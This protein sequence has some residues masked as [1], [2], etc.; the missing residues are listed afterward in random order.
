MKSRVRTPVKEDVS[1]PKP[2]A[3]GST[4]DELMINQDFCEKSQSMT[5]E[6]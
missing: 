5:E 4:Y 3:H 2:C 1:S 6:E